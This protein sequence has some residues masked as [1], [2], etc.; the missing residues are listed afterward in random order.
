M[1][2]CICILYQSNAEEQRVLYR[3]K[4]LDMGG[5]NLRRGGSKQSAIRLQRGAAAEAEVGKSV[6]LPG[7]TLEQR[8]AWGPT[9]CHASKA[10]PGIL[11]GYGPDS[12]VF[13]APCPNLSFTKA[14]DHDETSEFE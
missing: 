9:K 4:P 1:A 14:Y 7:S 6:S 11:G 12:S 8:E 13:S 5:A 3:W 10:A 2:P